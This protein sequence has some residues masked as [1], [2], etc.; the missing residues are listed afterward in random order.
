MKKKIIYSIALLILFGAKLYSQRIEVYS[1]VLKNHF[2]SIYDLNH[3]Q[4]FPKF[5][6][7]SGYSFGVN[8]DNIYLDSFNVKFSAKI[9]NYKGHIIN[10]GTAKTAGFDAEAEINKNLFE[11]G[12][13]PFNIKIVNNLNIRLGCEMGFYI[14][15]KTVGFYEE[16]PNGKFELIN[17]VEIKENRN[18]N[19]G[20]SGCIAYEIKIDK[21]LTI[22]P[23]YLYYLG[24]SEEFKE[25]FLGVNSIRQHISIG[26]INPIK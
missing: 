18:I 13:Y 6:E 15:D 26:I 4:S 11:L 10:R 16:W 8:I 7:G 23:Q 24:V 14:F 9:T 3:T 19:F 25:Y 5:K 17:D 2:Y 22:K 20:L 21:K 12:F 1:G